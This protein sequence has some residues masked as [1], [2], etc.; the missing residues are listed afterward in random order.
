[1]FKMKSLHV[2]LGG[3][4]L[5]AVSA[6]SAQITVKS[7][8]KI[9]FLGDSIT[10][11]GNW[12][13]GYI[14][15]VMSALE[16]NGIKAVKIPAGISGH[17][18][19][20]MLARL[21]RD[22]LK[23]KPQIMTLSCGV[24]DVWHGRRGVSLEDYRKNITEIVDK[25]QAAGIKVYI[26]TSTMIYENPD[27]ANNKKLA[28]YNDFLRS[29]AKEKNCVLVDLNADMQKQIAEIKA[30]YPKV[31]GNLLTVDGV[32]MNALGNIMMAEGILRAFGLNGEQIAKA[33]AVWDKKTFPQ[34]FMRLT[35]KEY[36]TLSEKAF[37]VN[38]SVPDYVTGLAKKDAQAR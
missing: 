38:K 20:Q 12:E 8:E 18:S 28:A 35:V 2:A 6:L 21:E 10:Q 31:K 16:A 25:A 4:L 26:L 37:K 1:M 27:H 13:S 22:V 11:Q 29:L 36:K 7:G 23:K 32:H 24:N 14:N 33:E 9:A 19:N 34:G 3:A 5:L 17:K 15:L 30:K